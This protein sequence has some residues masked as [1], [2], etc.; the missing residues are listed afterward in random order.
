[1]FKILMLIGFMSGNVVAGFGLELKTG[2]DFDEGIEYQLLKNTVVTET[3]RIEV[4]ELFWYQCPHCYALEDNVQDWLKNKSDETTF[5]RQ[6]A[7]FSKR[8]RVGSDYYYI[9]EKMGLVEE[10]HE[11]LFIAIHRDRKRIDS[12]A[13]LLAWLNDHG[14]E[15]SQ[16]D[17]YRKSFDVWMLSNKA[18]KQTKKY[19]IGGVP[20][21]IV[22][23]KYS[24][25]TKSAGSEA[26]VFKVV[27]FLVEKIKKGED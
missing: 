19:D 8:W 26:M 15:K 3:K 17:R 11:K 2:T 10:F 12:V 16:T 14:V 20:T 21:I 5:V 7:I 1:M 25:S 9:L 23:G 4:R 27:D 24:V 13:D 6:P 22:G 18:T